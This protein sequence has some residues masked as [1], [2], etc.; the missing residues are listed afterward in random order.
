M[1]PSKTL[2]VTTRD[3]LEKLPLELHEPI[4]ENLTFRDIIALDMYAL[5][6]G[7][8][9]SALAISPAWR[10]VFRYTYLP[11]K[12]EFEALLSLTVVAVGE[13]SY[14]LHLIFMAS[15]PVLQLI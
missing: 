5:E 9:A 2:Q 14:V 13:H 7:R 1:P 15:L 4:L 12:D 10:E 6:G 8:V 3:Y 11:R